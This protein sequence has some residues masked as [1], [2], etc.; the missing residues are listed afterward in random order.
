MRLSRLLLLVPCYLLLSL[1]GAAADR[2]N[3]LLI[4]VD[5]LNHWV[6]HLNRNHQ[7]ITPNIDKLAA[8]GVTFTRAYT[9]SPVCNPSRTAFLTGLRPSTSAVYGNATDWREV[10]PPGY[11]LPGWLQDQGYYTYGVGKLFHTSRHIR[12]EDWDEY[13]QNLG[14]DSADPPRTHSAPSPHTDGPPRDTLKYKAGD[15]S[16]AEL[17][18]GDAAQNDHATVSAA[19]DAL[20]T[21]SGDQPFFIA[22]GIFRP[23]LPWHVPV[24]YFDLYP[25]D[26]IQLP[27][28]R[29]DDLA[30]IPH[31]QP[32]PEHL[33]ILEEGSWKKA[34]RAYLACITYADMEVGRVLDA[35]AASP[36]ADNTVVI[37]MGDHG[38]HLGEKHTWRKALLWEEANR[39]P[40]IW[41]G[42][43]IH[44]TRGRTDAVVDL[45]SLWPT[46][47][48]LVG[49]PPP[50][51]VEGTSVKPLLRNP[52]L[53][54]SGPPALST[55]HFN[56]H[57]VRTDRWRY[58]RWDHGGEELYDHDADPYEWY[59]LLHPSQADRANG[60]NLPAIVAELRT[61]FPTTNRTVEEAQAH[62]AK[63]GIK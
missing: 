7:A 13:P 48:D 26:Q 14:D 54:W 45:M 37:L 57:T 60:L 6:N 17:A 24:K 22:C 62:F 51:H 42:P 19:I 49:A 29:E 59:N 40:Y 23:H 2:P 41:A 50:A 12:S 36:H 61:H 58:I 33:A 25:E 32:K 11:T 27:P 38:W 20:N 39:T 46:I 5:D 1:G 63:S 21:Q 31:A 16:I 28:Y 10:I 43:G 9:A 8:R 55:W 52:N 15:L 30:D 3:I 56:N 53:P 4:A 47:A 35:L 44:A 18:T 34:I